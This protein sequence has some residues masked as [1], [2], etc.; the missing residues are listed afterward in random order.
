[1]DTEFTYR[2]KQAKEL[3][4]KIALA[5][6]TKPEATLTF[7]SR[8]LSVIGFYLP[9]TCFSRKQ[10]ERLQVPIYQA[11]LPKLGYNRHIPLSVRFGPICY[12]GAAF[13]HTYTVEIFKHIQYITGLL[14]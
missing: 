14:R 7:H 11:I 3:G 4:Q 13:P 9:I 1:M 6:L 5:H 10:C 12:G 2:L 8:W